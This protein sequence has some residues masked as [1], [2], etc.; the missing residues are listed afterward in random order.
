MTAGVMNSRWSELLR[1]L[2]TQD[3]SVCIL[4]ANLN[5]LPC[6]HVGST[7]S[8]PHPHISIIVAT[9]YCIQHSF[10]FAA[11]LIIEQSIRL[12]AQCS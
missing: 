10:A 11:T 12:T 9:V 7:D 1:S 4:C 8:L 3:T 2:C 6:L 5:S